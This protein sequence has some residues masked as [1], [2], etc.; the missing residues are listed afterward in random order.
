L[1]LLAGACLFLLN[2]GGPS[3]WD[4]DEGR[5]STAAGEMWQSGDWLVPKFN[6][7]LRVDKPAL[8]YWLQAEAYALF[9]MTEFAARLPSALA[10]LLTVLLCYELGRR[11]FTA[12]TG[13]L[14]GLVLASSP[15]VCAAAR[16]ANPDALL[17]LCS[18]LTLFF[19]WRG[20]PGG[21][22]FWF[23]STGVASGLG[24][25]A[26]GPVGL[27][28]PAGV[29]GL[30]LLWNRNLRVLWDRRLLL[31]VVAFS[32]VALPWYILVAIETR[33]RFLQGFLMSHNV[34]RYLNPKEN[35]AGSMLYY[36]LVMLI[37]FAPW[38]FF[39][40]FLAWYGGWSAVRRPWSWTRQWWQR[41]RDHG[42]DEPSR[43]EEAAQRA[44]GLTPAV[45]PELAPAYRFLLCW[46][47]L[48]LIF[49]SIAAT[50]LPNYI[51]PIYVP[52]ALLLGRF[53]ERWRRGSIR[54]PALL[55]SFS[56]SGIALTG[57]LAACGVLLAGGKLPMRFMNDHYVAGIERWAWMGLI[58][59]VTA[60]IAWRYL[61]RNNPGGVI[62]SMTLGV[63]LFVIPMAAW[64]A[65]ALNLHKAPRPLVEKA[66]ACQRSR[67]IRIGCW[68]LEHL[69][70]L[71]FYCQR[72]VS[73]FESEAQVL[74][75]LRYSIPVYLFVPEDLWHSIEKK[76]DGA[77]RVLEGH[78]D[79][80]HCCRVVVVTNQ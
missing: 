2:L 8:L 63:I 69:P 76:V 16:F 50:K 26:K 14:G 41:A 30:F 25:L 67:E 46:I 34:D 9:G 12:E 57:L 73:H 44:A 31:G 53:L 1:L 61:R 60:I 68:Q 74:D 29:I 21:G 43:S 55:F 36:P 62:A 64:G 40:G 33:A 58:P 19:F 78:H 79:M 77:C 80:Y 65:V 52:L 4:V 72:D 45:N 48:Y 5:N 47:G 32:L 66:G 7:R 15:M 59:A 17:N 10:A 37:G 27:V 56:L 22:W 13:L 11:L 38:S 18:V 28:L 49:F 71:N 20:Y 39:L 75:F 42:G 54:P 51:L 70:S 6:G 24:V 3:L 35:H 23:V